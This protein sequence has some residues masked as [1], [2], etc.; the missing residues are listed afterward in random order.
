LA[1][2]PPG[3]LQQINFSKQIFDNVLNN[4]YASSGIRTGTERI[5]YRKTFQHCL[6]LNIPIH[7]V[8]LPGVYQ[9]QRNLKTTF[10]SF[11]A[12]AGCLR[13]LFSFFFF[14][15]TFYL[16]CPPPNIINSLF[17]HIHK[18]PLQAS[19]NKSYRSTRGMSMAE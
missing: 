19:Q 17:F 18:E 2:H 15:F 9:Q 7:E 8:A 13:H 3:I 1:A 12:L 10:F 14:L 16:F 11:P 6:A 5:R 4:A